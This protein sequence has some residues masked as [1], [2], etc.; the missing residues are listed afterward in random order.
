MRV[1]VYF[2]L[3]YQSRKFRTAR[4][5]A[6]TVRLREPA[7]MQPL[8]SFSSILKLAE[9][10]SSEMAVNVYRNTWYI[11]VDHNHQATFCPWPIFFAFLKPKYSSQRFIPENP[12]FLKH[13]PTHREH[14]GIQYLLL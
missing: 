8:F 11:P 9:A 5:Q 12:E 13:T 4:F 2:V 6:I 14:T 3:L 7:I 10:R 1:S